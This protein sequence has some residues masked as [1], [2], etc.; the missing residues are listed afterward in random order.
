MIEQSE[1]YCLKHPV[2]QLGSLWHSQGA[3][4]AIK[5]RMQKF[6]RCCRMS[7]LTG[8]QKPGT[9]VS[10]FRSFSVRCKAFWALRGGAGSGHDLFRVPSISGWVPLRQLHIVGLLII[11]IIIII[12]IVRLL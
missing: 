2:L 11:I 9:H 10:L 5:I 3:E 12:K 7:A 1:S 4:V 8:L 6:C